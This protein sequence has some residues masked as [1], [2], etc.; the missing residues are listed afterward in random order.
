MK[1]Q[2]T[3]VKKY[4]I[5]I[6]EKAIN[7]KFNWD[8]KFKIAKAAGFDFIEISIDESDDK[9]ARLDW[10]NQQVYKLLEIAI[11]NNMYINSMCLS[12]NR[13]FPLGSK[14][15]NT[16]NQ[17]LE[18]IKK[19]F[20]LAKK[21]GIRIIQLAGY[22]EYYNQ[23]DEITKKYFI[24]NMKIVC[25]LAQYYSIQI[26]F[27]SMDTPFMGTLTKMLNIINQ[28]NS[29]M[30][31]CYPDIGNL[32]QFAKEN[33]EAEI[34]IAK[35]KIVA[36]HFKDTRPNVFKCVPFGSGTVDFVFA[37]KAIFKINYYGP[38][39]IE[40]WSENNQEETFEQNIN[41]IKKAHEFFKQKYNEALNGFKQNQ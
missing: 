6:Y 22:D 20:I 29:P 34:E 41:E 25:C 38:F 33:F 23:N 14:N 37:F 17:G 7:K 28:L 8:Q 24:E 4:K 27:E 15:Q 39:L 31:G 16:R 19:A 21:L 12:A 3:E 18:I 11:E 30:L 1:S 5:G 35:N 40:M 26:A 10:S 36:F 13:R 32:T 9:I 2:N